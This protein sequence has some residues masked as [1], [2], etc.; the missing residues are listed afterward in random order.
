MS[1]KTIKFTEEEQKVAVA[2]IVLSQSVEG[3]EIDEIIQEKMF[4]ILNGTANAKELV[5]A[6][7]ERYTSV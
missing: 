1:N 6:C 4:K 5:K 2:N 7:L 3:F